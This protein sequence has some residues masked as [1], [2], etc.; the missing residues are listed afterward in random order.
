MKKNINADYI[1]LNHII[2]SYVG[3]NLS[4][5]APSLRSSHPT[6]LRVEGMRYFDKEREA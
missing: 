1:H 3:S 5:D 6:H 2:F 4:R